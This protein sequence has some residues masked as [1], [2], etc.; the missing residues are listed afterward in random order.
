MFGRLLRLAALAGLSAM[1]VSGNAT[2]PAPQQ[3]FQA[4]Y[5]RGELIVGIPYLEPT[6]VAGAKIRTPERLDAAMATHL[7]ERLKLPLRL[8]QIPAEHAKN[9]LE[10][11]QVDTVIIDRAIDLDELLTELGMLD[12]ATGYATQSKAVIRSDT[13]LRNTR[14]IAGHSVCVSQAAV[15]AQTWARQRGATVHIYKV[16]SD[17]LVAVREGQCDLSFVDDAVWLPLMRFP[18]WRAFSATLPGGGSRM[19]R[20]WLLPASSHESQ[21]WLKREMRAWKSQ[22][23]WKTFGDKWARDVAFDVYLDQEVP[24]CHVL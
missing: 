6:A 19:E 1:M 24:D 8:R 4:A 18:E 23:V 22:G 20:H 15:S 13:A 2:E 12:V 7:A 16:P 14:D 17:A 5:A 10:A 21:A 11:G 9:M 3:A